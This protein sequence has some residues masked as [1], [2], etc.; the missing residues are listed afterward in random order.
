MLLNVRVCGDNLLLRGELGALLE[1]KIANGTRQGKVA[2]D[3]A[4]VNESSCSCDTVLLVW[5][6]GV[7]GAPDMSVMG[8]RAKTLSADRTE[9]TDFRAGACDLEKAAWRGP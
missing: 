8:T 9:R 7:G 6:R 5:K 4:K 3:T 1:L 2:I